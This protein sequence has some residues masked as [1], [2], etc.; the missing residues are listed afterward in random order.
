MLKI[1]NRVN[2]KGADIMLITFPNFR[3]NPIVSL[4]AVEKDISI[5]YSLDMSLRDDK[6]FIL[7]VCKMYPNSGE[8][9]LEGAS[10]RLRED[11]DFRREVLNQD[12]L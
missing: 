3:S 7:N 8:E 1:L 9:I 11:P 12:I 6:T 5:L 4:A 10:E 2:S